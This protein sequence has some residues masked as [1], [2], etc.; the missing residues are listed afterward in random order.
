MKKK[1]T[2]WLQPPAAEDYQAEVEA[3]VDASGVFAIHRST[4][5]HDDG[6]IIAGDPY[7]E[8][9]WTLTHVP[10]GYAICF[11]RTKRSASVAGAALKKLDIPWAEVERMD[12]RYRDIIEPI[13]ADLAIDGIIYMS[14][15]HEG[16]IIDKLK[17]RV[18]THTCRY[19]VEHI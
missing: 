12:E 8:F 7:P 5:L 18:W 4:W 16:A 2:I 15:R 9:R 13:L 10:T 6:E 19:G 11:A 14:E 3:D 1:I 17:A